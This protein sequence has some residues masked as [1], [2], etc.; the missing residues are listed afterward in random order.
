[1]PVSIEIVQ[2]IL[3]GFQGQYAHMSETQ[4]AAWARLLL[5]MLS[6][7]ASRGLCAPLGGS[8]HAARWCAVCARG[9]DSAI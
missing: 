5:A 3:R 8:K 2:E 4:K 1:V 6:L 9:A 7:A